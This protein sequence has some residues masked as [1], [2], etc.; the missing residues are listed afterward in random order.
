M[1]KFLR[2][3]IVVLAASVYIPL[4]ASAAAIVYS[5]QHVGGNQ[6]TYQYVLTASAGDPDIQEFT[7]FFDRNT[8]KNI[9]VI[10]S[11]AQWDS[12]AVQPDIALQSDGF[13]D[14]LAL[15]PGLLPGETV[16]GFSVMFDFLGS[17]TP[18]AQRFDI[19]DPATFAILASSTTS[20]SVVIPPPTDIPE[21]A[22]LALLALPLAILISRY[23]RSSVLNQ[24]T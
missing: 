7:V 14:S 23:G 19:V 20:P 9:A 16:G 24:K 12:L 3:L 8:Y 15:G 4:S 17:G 21:P 18:G 1:R 2:L 22:P 5:T 6:W 11:P 10:N 13:F